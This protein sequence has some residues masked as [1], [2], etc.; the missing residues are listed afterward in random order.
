MQAGMVPIPDAMRVRKENQVSS[1]PNTTARLE[2][3]LDLVKRA[4]EGD[5]D[6]FASL[7]YSHKAR[8]YSV[9]LRMTNNT[10][11]A[12][13]L[14]QDA[15][16]Q[17][18]RKLAT[19]RGDSALS[20]WLYRIAVNTVLMHFRKKALKQVSLDEPYSQDAKLVRREYGSR[21]DR[22]S[23]TVDRIALARAITELP[24]GY[25]TIFLLHEV[26]GYEHQEIAELLD[27]SVGNSK[28]QL[29]KAKL[30]IRELLGHAKV[31]KETAAPELQ[32]RAKRRPESRHTA[33][34]WDDSIVPDLPIQPATMI[35]SAPH[36]VATNA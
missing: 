28:S 20:T 8:I 3:D 36:L 22:L 29:H 21:D 11:E 33:E 27:C 4:Q 31:E 10:A 30:R 15:F 9:C 34:E 5:T 6:A 12:E 26:E 14:T 25:R 18:F 13:D 32:A 2:T 23:G 24:Y 19:F 7:F 35:P 16:L 17:V 1:E